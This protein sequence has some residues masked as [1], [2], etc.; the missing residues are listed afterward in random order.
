MYW[1]HGGG[2]S[3]GW[4]H[5]LP[6]G[7][8][9]RDNGVIVVTI[10]YRLGIFGWLSHPALRASAETPEDAS[11]NFGTLDMIRGLEW[12]RENIASFGGNPD[13]VTVF[14][15]SAGGINVFSLLL[16]PRAK[17]LF[18]AAISQSGAANT[19]TRSQ[20]ERY[21]DDEDGQE[22]GLPG[23]SLELVIALLGQAGRASGREQAKQVAASLAAAETE[24]F[25]RGFRMEELLQPFI[26]VMGDEPMPI[27]ITPTIFRDGHVVS[28]GDPLELFKT[29]EAYNA[30]PFIA[31]TNREES[32]LFFLMSSPHIS[33]T[34][35]LPT[36]FVNERL[37]DVEGEYGGLAWRAMGADEPIS[38]MSSVQGGSVWA[39]RFDW[40]EQPTVFGADLSKMLGAA[41][42]MELFFVF[43]LTDLGFGNRFLFD[44]QPS[45]ERLSRQM[46]SYWAN[47]AHTLRPGRG[48]E[49][50]LL[51]WAPWDPE[52]GGDKY[53]IFDSD[54]D[55]GIEM[56]R[57]EID[58][59][60]ILRRASKEPRLLNDEE[61]CRVFRN[62][63]QWSSALTPEQYLLVGDGAC[64][65]FPIENRIFFPSLSHPTAG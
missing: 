46:R 58:Q 30:V 11:G 15:E 32:K 7:A 44:D 10:N 40:D 54:R 31:G 25:L 56:G 20:A 12:V 21:T 43:G 42:A 24:A 59:A 22:A 51:E 6:S 50:D 57:D 35:G 49:G 47:F 3:M 38:R 61:R 33:R 14:G 63:V 9:A 23:S 13:R 1:I 65:A 29:E 34:F 48:Q 16:S 17:G 27:Y 37:Y 45:A 41:H 62:F 19:S 2:N 52:P 28:D 8:F 53:L 36:G 18:H 5:Q 26:D 60:S 4:G 64:A 39:Y 55:G